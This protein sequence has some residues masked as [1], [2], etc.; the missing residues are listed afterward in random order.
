MRVIKSKK[1]D[2]V[3]LDKYNLCQASTLNLDRSISIEIV[4]EL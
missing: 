4:V 2:F 3:I 1:F